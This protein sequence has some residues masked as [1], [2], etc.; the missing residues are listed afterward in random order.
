LVLSGRTR[1]E[2]VRYQETGFV[3]PDARLSG[4]LVLTPQ[5]ATLKR[6]AATALG[7][8]FGGEA[9][10]DQY[11]D[12]RID[13]RVS[14]L[15][16]SSLGT[17]L[18][19]GP[20]G[21]RGTA[22][23][24]AHLE[25][26]ISG[27]GPAV[28]GSAT[29]ET[30]LEIAPG[31]TGIPV[32]GLAGIR[33][34]Y[35]PHQWTFDNLS[36]KLPHSEAVVSGTLGQRMTVMLDTT[37]VEDLMP[38]FTLAGANRPA[39]GFEMLRGAHAHFA[40]SLTGPAGQPA[41]EG[42]LTAEHVRIEGQVIDRITS[43]F[44]A[45]ASLASVKSMAVE[46]GPVRGRWRGTLGLANW[47]PRKSSALELAGQIEGVDLASL[48]KV[49]GLPEMQGTASAT[50]ELH[51]TLSSPQG[52][53]HG[54][55]RQLAILGERAAHLTVDATA[56]E[57]RLEVSKLTATEGK[58]TLE[59]TGRFDHPPSDWKNGEME[60]T[61]RVAGFRLADCRACVR[62]APEWSVVADANASLKA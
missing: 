47:S 9:E 19:T 14:N 57:R 20:L 49:E 3:I 28:H 53:V 16:I 44:R 21:W 30:L 55:V 41:L 2:H 62:L 32:Q 27:L 59:L 37:D 12:L 51:G 35:P 42:H 60:A 23:G 1:A 6:L 26:R 45:N 13:G 15:D 24:P 56:T 11:R 17:L 34:S 46:Q 5:K 43:D 39:L 54:D 48:G 58:S 10:L 4:D 61:L 8:T 52:K 50:F 18:G 7:A 29:V 31:A 25:A 38:L 22:S 40:G 36:L 33:Y